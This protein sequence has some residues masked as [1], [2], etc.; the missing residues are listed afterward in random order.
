MVRRFRATAAA[1]GRDAVA[2]GA[3][4]EVLPFSDGTFD[5][6]VTTLTLC[7][8]KDLDAVVGEI[9]RVLR[10]DGQFLF[11]EHVVSHS[12]MVHRLQTWANPIWRF[13]TTGCNL[14]RDIGGAIRSAGFRDVEYRDFSLS[15]LPGIKIPNIVGSARV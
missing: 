2:V 12:P 4:G 11:Y 6:V 14:Q 9:R 3:V 15:V 1:H 13:V 5:T 8:V 7:M 10:P